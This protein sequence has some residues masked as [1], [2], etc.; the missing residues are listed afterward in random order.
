ME[1]KSNV[2]G[3]RNGIL[4]RTNNDNTNFYINFIYDRKYNSKLLYNTDLNYNPFTQTL[5]AP[6][7]SGNITANKVEVTDSDY[8]G[9]LKLTFSDG[10]N[11]LL[12]NAGLLYHP[13]FRILKVESNNSQT[14]Q[15]L[16]KNSGQSAGIQIK[17]APAVTQY[18]ANITH[19]LDILKI[20]NTGSD[21]E[22]E[23]VGSGTIYIYN[24]NGSLTLN[25]SGNIVASG[26]YAGNGSLLT[27][28]TTANLNG[29]IQN[30]QLQNDTITIGST[31][32]NLGDTLTTLS[33]LTSVTSDLF[34]GKIYIEERTD[35]KDYS[36]L[37]SNIPLA[38]N[39]ER[40]I[41]TDTNI[42]W[43]P[44]LSTLTCYRLDGY[45][46]GL[47]LQTFSNI[48]PFVFCDGGI[49]STQSVYSTTPNDL[50]WDN[51]NKRLGI[52]TA[53]P[54]VKLHVEDSGDSIGVMYKNTTHL[55]EQGFYASAT[56][57]WVGTFNNQDMRI[58]ANSLTKMTINST[59]GNVGIGIDS[60]LTKLEIS[61]DASEYIK[62]YNQ[63]TSGDR[64]GLIMCNDSSNN[65]A[66]GDTPQWGGFIDW[67]VGNDDLFI[68]HY[69]NYVRNEYIALDKDGNV[70]I[71][72]T[73]PTVK[74]HLSGDG[75]QTGFII[76]NTES[77]ANSWGFY[78]MGTARTG[79]LEIQSQGGTDTIPFTIEIKFW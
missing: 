58:G 48:K 56:G 32:I 74:L 53:N 65:L 19:Y 73:N 16:L 33:G 64:A 42:Y 37:F 54:S 62:V 31:Q 5:T 63:G 27:S 40:L 76:Q 50:C 38:P 23:Q 20:Q 2:L 28:L 51:N 79:R 49:I 1:T 43:N 70:G 78:S 61:G 39:N 9:N 67:E 7:F 46:T 6:N 71:G 11:N 60:P 68:G 30:N 36:L 69:R 35:N 3:L 12:D 18:E 8:N 17:G 77:G 52:G 59:T 34:D 14:Y 10:N 44:Y 57:G 4:S 66:G 41:N 13:F 24:A 55:T 15:L 75:T 72:T 29:L 22:I 26:I 21:T 25:S 47:E 45:A